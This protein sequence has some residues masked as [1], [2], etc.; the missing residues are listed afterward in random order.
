MCI[1]FNNM[2]QKQVWEITPKT[3]VP[4]G[5]KSIGSRWVLAQKDCKMRRKRIQ[6]DTKKRLSKESC[7]SHF[8]PNTTSTNG[9]KNSISIGSWTI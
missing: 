4:A 8:G 5:R 7:T 3:K 1:D 2:N 6:S 9:H